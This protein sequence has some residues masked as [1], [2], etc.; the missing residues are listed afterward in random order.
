MILLFFWL[1]QH[2]TFENV[3]LGDSNPLSDTDYGYFL[4][5]TDV[6]LDSNYIA[7]ATLKSACHNLSSSY[8]VSEQLSKTFGTSGC[9]SPVILAQK[10]M[11]WIKKEW[12]DKL[13]FVVWTGDNQCS[14]PVIPSLGNNDVVPHN[15]MIDGDLDKNTNQLLKYYFDL[16]QDWIPQDQHDQFQLQGSFIHTIAPHLKVLSLN[17]MYFIKKNDRS[18]G[19]KRYGSAK[20]QMDWFEQQLSLAKK[21]GDKVLVI[22][23]VPPTEEYKQSCFSGYI[24]IASMYSDIIVGHLYGH[25]NKDHFLLYD[26]SQLQQR[27]GQNLTQE[28]DDDDKIKVNRQYAYHYR[29]KIRDTLQQQQAFKFKVKIPKFAR[30]LHKM[31]AKLDPQL[32]SNNHND[33]SHFTENSPVIAIQVNPSVLPK[34][35]PTLRI[36]R[37]NK[38]NT[39]NNV[40]FGKIMDY[41]QYFANITQWDQEYTSSSSSSLPSYEYQLSYS[42]LK[43]YG[44][45][46]LTAES[47][48]NFAKKMVNPK[49]KSEANLWKDYVNNI[50][51]RSKLYF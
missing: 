45:K 17:T 6:H 46:E 35:Y 18:D 40:D 29:N 7:G 34:Y 21:N 5:I 50:F 25:L 9:D 24:H 26:A 42:T 16:W 15:Q 32:L 1:L 48:F 12:K 22:G 37:Y 14:I 33:P 4:H 11:D 41:Q 28:Q 51:I 13:D 3:K 10:T 8:D 44:M 36:Y 19:C 47:F 49:D 2:I 27:Q 43:D 31:Y 20:K 38:K 23:H 39:T 30:Q